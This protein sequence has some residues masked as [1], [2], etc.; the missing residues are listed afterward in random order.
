M[1]VYACDVCA[2]VY[3]CVC[4]R[5]RPRVRIGCRGGGGGG[6]VPIAR[7]TG[8]CHAQRAAGSP[9]GDRSRTPEFSR[10]HTLLSL[11]CQI[12]DKV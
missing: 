1:R 11:L 12:A 3:V 10:R 9:G 5:A 2:R 8:F 6:D 7:E 4:V